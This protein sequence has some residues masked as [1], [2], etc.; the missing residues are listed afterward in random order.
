M[1]TDLCVFGNG[2]QTTSIGLSQ[3]GFQLQNVWRP[4]C[5]LVKGRGESVQQIRW[6]DVQNQTLITYQPGEQDSVSGQQ[7]VELAP[8]PRDAS[9]ITI[10]RVS[11]RDE[12]CYTCIFDLY[13]KGSREGQTCLT[14]T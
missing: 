1:S 7:H 12:G 2:V 5:T 4:R 9:A 6:M 10:K 8:S 13:P 14:V 11:Y 3:A